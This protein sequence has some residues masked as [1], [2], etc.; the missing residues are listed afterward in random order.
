[1][2]IIFSPSLFSADMLFLKKELDSIRDSGAQWIHLDVMDGL[3]APNYFLSP[4]IISDIRRG[5]NLFL[6]THLMIVNPEQYISE[7][8]AAGS[9]AITVHYEAC[10]NCAAVLSSIK[11]HSCL[12]GLAVCPQTSVHVLLPYLEQTDLVL[13]MS[14]NPGTKGQKFRSEALDKI[15]ELKSIREAHKYHYR[16]SVDGGITLENA[17][18]VKRAGSDV[19]V[20]GSSFF[21]AQDRTS[22]TREITE[23]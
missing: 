6:D 17:A 3:F 20:S 11:R 16:I 14:V 9:N 10:R 5:S 18:A 23:T 21:S 7:F 22:F 19:L 12:S 13:V 1:M 2:G 4:K 15:A 8:A